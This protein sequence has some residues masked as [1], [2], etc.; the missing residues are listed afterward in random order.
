M[1]RRPRQIEPGGIYHVT[2]RGNDRRDVF[3]SD[4]DRLD[5]LQRLAVL[6]ERHA[7]TVYAHC[8]MTN[9]Y[10]LVLQV[11]DDGLSK[12]MCVLN[13]HF[14]RSANRR[15]GRTGHL[16]QR[17]FHAEPTGRQ[18][19]LLEAIRYLAL[20]PIRAGLCSRPEQ[21]RW[22]SYRACA[23]LDYAPD[24]LAVDNVLKLFA[25]DPAAARAAYCSFVQLGLVS[26]AGHRVR[27]LVAFER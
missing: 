25:A 11:A 15:H 4:R 17:R 14:A 13:A 27:E 22:S 8:L 2:I 10:H 6:V 16:F 26:G 20:N 9:H 18:S 3:V 12:G 23:G 21:W 7:W 19:H 1:P 24:F 5:L